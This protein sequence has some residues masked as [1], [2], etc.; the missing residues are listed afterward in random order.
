MGFFFFGIKCRIKNY[1]G[2]IQSDLRIL[3]IETFIC[4]MFDS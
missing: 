1:F 4:K 3:K 2:K